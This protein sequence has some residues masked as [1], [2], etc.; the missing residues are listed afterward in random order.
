MTFNQL[1]EHEKQCLLIIA[2]SGTQVTYSER[3]T[4][5]MHSLIDKGLVEFRSGGA[6]FVTSKGWAL[7]ISEADG[8]ATRRTT[9][10]ER[11]VGE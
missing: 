11:S 10:V 2:K 1:T 6:N 4:P 8:I 5:S 3:N 7:L 9:S